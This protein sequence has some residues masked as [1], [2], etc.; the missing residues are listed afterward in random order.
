[1]S[2]AQDA[3]IACA[4]HAGLEA[5][6]ARARWSRAHN[7]ALERSAGRSGPVVIINGPAPLVPTVVVP[8]KASQPADRT[9][10]D[11]REMLAPFNAVIRFEPANRRWILQLP[12]ADA[13]PP[14]N[15]F[16][17]QLAKDGSAFT[18]AWDPQ[19]LAP[20]KPSK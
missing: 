6:A 10:A 13:A 7:A 1:V 20:A 9:I 14:L 4:P 8:L 12:P 2:L 19:N 11:L 17:W 15:T 3:W 18:G 16:A 5:S